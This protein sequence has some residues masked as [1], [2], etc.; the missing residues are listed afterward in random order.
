M[1]QDEWKIIYETYSRS[2]YLYALSLTENRQDA[3]DLLQETFVKAYLS[4]R[5][6]GSIK[7]WL[8]T[9]LRNEFYNLQRKRKWEIP[10]EEEF[11]DSRASEENILEQI[12]QKEERRHLFLEI[13]KLPVS[14]KEVLIESIY[15]QMKDEEIGKL[16][17]FT[18]ENVRKIRSRAKQK[19]LENMKEGK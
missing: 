1:H 13:Q 15:F 19:L 5:E 18:N 16:H 12:I 6:T 8:V 17:G 2:L 11:S 10:G 4:Y 7:Y 9:V 3:E 14:M